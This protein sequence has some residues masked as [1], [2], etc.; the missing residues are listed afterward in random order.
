MDKFNSSSATSSFQMG[1][2]SFAAAAL[3][4]LPSPV[5]GASLESVSLGSNE[6]QVRHQHSQTID[7]STIIKPEM[8]GSDE[9]S[10]SDSK[11]AICC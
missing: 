1:E 2:A 11:K 5:S 8:L 4:P 6:R 10:G 9:A 3:Q 7:G